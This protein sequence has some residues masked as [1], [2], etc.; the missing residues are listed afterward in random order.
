MRF[1]LIAAGMGTA[2]AAD[3]GNAAGAESAESAAEGRSET[4]AAEAA[5]FC[6]AADAANAGWAALHFSKRS[7]SR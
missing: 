2:E 1:T 4:G 3:F 7:G 5:V 6:N